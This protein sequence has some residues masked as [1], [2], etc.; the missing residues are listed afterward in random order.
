[1][2]DAS[3]IRSI[4]TGSG[5]LWPD[6]LTLLEP[7]KTLDHTAIAR[8]ALSLIK[9][10][11]QSISPEWWAQGVTVLYEQHIGKRLP[12]QRCDGAF[13]VTVS[14][15]LPGDMDAVFELWQSW[16]AGLTA[17]NGIPLESEPQSS[18]TDK[19]RYWR[20]K[21][22]DGTTLSVNIQTKPSGDKSSLAINH[23]KL[24]TAE[25]VDLWREFWKA[26]RTAA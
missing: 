12:G 15:T 24:S 18:R 25:D 16:T 1:M 14:R 4:E 2:T 5:I 3:K 6:W 19:W 10:R 20:C 22:A 17:F 26:F 21:L 8:E 9:E 13:S 11:G 7:F 23:D